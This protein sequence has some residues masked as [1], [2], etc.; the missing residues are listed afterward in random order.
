MKPKW[1]V[2]NY[3]IETRAL[4]DHARELRDIESTWTQRCMLIRTVVTEAREWKDAD[5]YVHT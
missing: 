3:H 4:N 1:E 2:M 5:A